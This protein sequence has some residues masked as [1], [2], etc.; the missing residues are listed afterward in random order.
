[1][2]S[3]VVH[4]DRDVL[5]LVAGGGLGVAA[6]SAAAVRA[7]DRRGRDRCVAADAGGQPPQVA[8]DLVVVG[9]QPERV[10]VGAE[11][12]HQILD[13]VLDQVGR[14]ARDLQLLG[15]RLRQREQ[16][17]LARGSPLPSAR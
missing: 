7:A 16:V 6:A 8:D 13:L 9:G 5:V 15:Q 10:Q 1:M 14:V 4:V 11:R 17:A 12:A 3:V 2:P